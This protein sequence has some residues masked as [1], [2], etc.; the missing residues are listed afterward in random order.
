MLEPRSLEHHRLAAVLQETIDKD[1]VD[2]RRIV[3]RKLL[4]LNSFSYNDIQEAL[5]QTGLLPV[6][7]CSVLTAL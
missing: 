4:I 1:A 7:T 3:Y 6:I 2:E 5:W